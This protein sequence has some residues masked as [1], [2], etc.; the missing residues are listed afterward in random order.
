V[1]IDARRG[2]RSEQQ[3]GGAAA[4]AEPSS[5]DQ[6]GAAAAAPPPPPPPPDGGARSLR[7]P[8]LPDAAAA[9]MGAQA[10][11]ERGAMAPE[12]LATLRLQARWAGATAQRRAATVT[13][14]TGGHTHRHPLPPPHPH[15]ALPRSGPQLAVASAQETQAA[16]VERAAAARDARLGALARRAAAVCAAA[17]AGDGAAPGGLEEYGRSF[18]AVLDY[19]VAAAGLA[20][21]PEPEPPQQQ[22]PQQEPLAQ[23][24][25]GGSIGGGGASRGAAAARAAAAAALDSVLPLSAVA[26]WVTLPPA[27]RLAQL[28]PLARLTLGIVLF[29]SGW[30]AAGG[31][32]GAAAGDAAA[33]PWG[34][35]AGGSRGSGGGSSMAGASRRAR[36][37]GGSGDGGAGAAAGGVDAVAPAAAAQQLERAAALGRELGLLE[38]ASWDAFR[39]AAAPPK[40]SRTPSARGAPPRPPGRAALFCVQA[41]A[42]L[43]GARA[44]AAQGLAACRALE[45]ALQAELQAVRRGWEWDGGWGRGQCSRRL[46]QVLD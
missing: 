39:A 22:R 2:W 19:V 15:P 8:D 36:G 21:E 4:L 41:A 37:S 45:A 42:A 27:E 12:T 1:L 9:E 26:R 6:E 29:H 23:G 38:G 17:A 3:P 25:T 13:W 24:A 14:L 33:A 7:G 20:P 43:R 31:S 16:A 46:H 40:G 28:A 18:N 34:G 5:E 11:A 10:A 35:R 44:D 30:G 32:S